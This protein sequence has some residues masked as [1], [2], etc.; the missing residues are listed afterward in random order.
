MHRLFRLID[1]L[2]AIFVF[3]IGLLLTISQGSVMG[4]LFM[5]LAVD[6]FVSDRVMYNLL[7]KYG[8]ERFKRMIDK[9]DKTDEYFD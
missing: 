1:I 4:L 2:Y 5:V 7:E 3:V 8:V 6:K 9:N